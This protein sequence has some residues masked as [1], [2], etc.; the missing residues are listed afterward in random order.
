MVLG[1]HLDA[2]LQVLPDVRL[3]HRLQALHAVLPREGPEE[4]DEPVGVEEVG[5]DHGALDVV[6]VGVVLE[7]ALQQPGLLAQGGDV[8]PVVV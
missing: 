5:V 7:R 2:H 6:E 4:V 8:R 3:Q 1:G